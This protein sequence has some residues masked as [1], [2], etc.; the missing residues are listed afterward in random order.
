[1]EQFQG[2]KNPEIET[3]LMTLSGCNSVQPPKNAKNKSRPQRLKRYATPRQVTL[4]VPGAC[5]DAAPPS[6][7]S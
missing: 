7:G 4:V 1:M 5:F 3:I 2:H 6:A